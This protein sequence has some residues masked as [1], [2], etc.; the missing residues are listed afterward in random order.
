MFGD[1]PWWANGPYSPG[2]GSYAGVIC[3]AREAHGG[4]ARAI[5]GLTRLPVNSFHGGNA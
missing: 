4:L 3:K 2:L 5:A 1:F